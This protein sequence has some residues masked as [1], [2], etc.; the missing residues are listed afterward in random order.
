M[1]Y[2]QNLNCHHCMHYVEI[3]NCHHC[4]HYIEILN[5]HHCMHYV[6]TLHCNHHALQIV[7][8]NFTPLHYYVQILNSK[9]Y[10]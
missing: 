8:I 2:V 1:H 10:G 4:M 5:C 6:T 3:L 9:L 7:Y